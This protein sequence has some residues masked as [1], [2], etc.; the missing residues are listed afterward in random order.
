MSCDWLQQPA[1]CPTTGKSTCGFSAGVRAGGC[2]ARPQFPGEGGWQRLPPPPAPGPTTP[3]I[4]SRNSF[5][6]YR[7][8][9]PMFGRF[10]AAACGRLPVPLVWQPLLTWEDSEAALALLFLTTSHVRHAP[11]VASP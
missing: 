3:Q 10:P 1:T 11:N 8:S 5:P 4:S 6:A 7:Q 2:Q 9:M